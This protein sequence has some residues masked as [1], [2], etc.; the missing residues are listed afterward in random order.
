MHVME[1]L[2]S[3]CGLP[4][5]IRMDNSLE[6]GLSIFVDWCEEYDPQPGKPQQ[7]DFADKR[8]FLSL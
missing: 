4:K 8:K 7:N 1:Q 3:D 5:Q 2:K 6:L